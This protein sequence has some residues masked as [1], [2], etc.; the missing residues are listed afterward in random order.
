MHYPSALYAYLGQLC[1]TQARV[2]DCACGTGQASH[3]LRRYF[4]QIVATDISLNQ[5]KFR[6][7]DGV[8]FLQ[9][10]AEQPPFSR[11]SFDLVCVAQ[12]LHWFDLKRF[13]PALHEVLKPGG[14]IAVWGANWPLF[15][16]D[17]KSRFENYVL[18][19]LRGYWSDRNQLLWNH[20]RDIEFPY[21]EIRAPQ[22]SMSALLTLDEFFD[23]V[24]TFSATRAKIADYGDQFLKTAYHEF[25]RVWPATDPAKDIE[26][27]FVLVVHKKPKGR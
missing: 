13:W 18:K 10:S 14:V 7:V 3:G 15:H 26:F 24:R 17:L 20:Y 4:K 12:A 2:W 8:S 9:A 21:E 23:L 5:L 19:P 25:Q 6:N 22:F 27:D 16:G 1:N 11:D